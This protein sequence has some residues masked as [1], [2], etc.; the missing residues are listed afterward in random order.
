MQTTV[1]VVSLVSDNNFAALFQTQTRLCHM[2]T[3]EL[4]LEFENRRVSVV[5]ESKSENALKPS[6][7]PPPLFLASLWPCGCGVPAVLSLARGLGSVLSI[8]NRI[9]L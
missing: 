9:G 8:Q 7:F 3:R 6:P 2:C 1:V 4:T 5:V